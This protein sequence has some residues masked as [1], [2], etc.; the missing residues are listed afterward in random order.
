MP[1]LRHK[2][3]D[4]LTGQLGCVYPELDRKTLVSSLFSFAMNVAMRR[5]AVSSFGILLLMPSVWAVVSIRSCNADMMLETAFSSNVA[6]F[7]SAR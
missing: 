1:R 7:F 5:V 4:P 2:M 3:L 6:A